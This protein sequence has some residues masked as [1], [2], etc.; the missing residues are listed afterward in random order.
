MKHNYFVVVLIL[1][2]FVT[3]SFVTHIW[4]SLILDVQASFSLSL[5]LVGF[6]PTFL[7]LA[8]GLSIPVGMLAERFSAKPMQEHWI[9]SPGMAGKLGMQS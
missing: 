4:G 9:S 5:A 6:I 8:Y 7:F 1:L 2:V 3:I